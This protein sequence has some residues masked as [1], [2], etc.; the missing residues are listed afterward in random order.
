MR[1]L[2]RAAA[3][4]VLGSCAC[5]PAQHP[6][7]KGTSGTEDQLQRFYGLRRLA[8]DSFE[9]GRLEDARAQALELLDLA[10]A[11]PS[12]WNHGN[13]IHDGNLVLGRLA[14]RAG[15]V[16][17]AKAFLKKAGQTPGSPQLDTFGPN[18]TLARDLL[19]RGEREAVLDYFHLCSRFWRLHEDRLDAWTATVKAGGIPDFRANLVY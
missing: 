9:A 4:L 17:E 12:D 3:L 18:M 1:T 14:L 19:V 16:D 10:R 8:K 6:S 13:G 11:Y 7:A 5:L 2:L 15:S